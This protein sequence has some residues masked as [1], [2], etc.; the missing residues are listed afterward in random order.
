MEGRAMS[1]N[2]PC[3]CGRN[4][5]VHKYLDCGPEG[6]IIEPGLYETITDTDRMDWIERGGTV[7][8][9]LNGAVFGCD[10]AL[11][12]GWWTP[13]KGAN[14][15]RPRYQTARE[16]IDAAIREAQPV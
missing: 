16:A 4:L 5:P 10:P 6:A 1:E 2:W 8:I 13:G 11:G 14:K 15:Q 3:R 12:R 7:R 9:D